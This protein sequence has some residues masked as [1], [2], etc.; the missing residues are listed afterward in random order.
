MNDAHHNIDAVCAVCRSSHATTVMIPG[1]NV[2]TASWTK[3]YDGFLMT[4]R[5][6]HPDRTEYVCVDSVMEGRPGSND[7]HNGALFYFHPGQVW[8]PSLCTLRKQQ[9]RD[10]CRLLQVTFSMRI[11]IDLTLFVDF[12]FG[13]NNENNLAM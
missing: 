12:V 10:L 5:Y 13:R 9:D 6:N 7:D 11:M 4:E 2:C 3:Q 1:T 8:Q